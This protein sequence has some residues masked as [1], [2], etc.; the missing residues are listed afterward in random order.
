MNEV[1]TH[2]KEINLLSNYRVEQTLSSLN[3]NQLNALDCDE[4]YFESEILPE[5]IKELC[6]SPA[7]GASHPL[8]AP[9]GGLSCS[10]TKRKEVIA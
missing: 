8:G 3:E 9:L 1:Q 5:I 2:F 4:Q 10:L 7:M 6:Q